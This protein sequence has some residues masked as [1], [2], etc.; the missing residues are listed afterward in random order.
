MTKLLCR[1]IIDNREHQRKTV[2]RL[3][4]SPKGGVAMDI[5]A[6]LTLL[7]VVIEIIKLSNSKK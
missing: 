2:R 1:D 5:M 6:V 7:I 4:T 3:S